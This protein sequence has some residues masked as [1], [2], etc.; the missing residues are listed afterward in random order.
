MT[1]TTFDSDEW[2]ARLGASLEALAPA[3]TYTVSFESYSSHLT[4]DEFRSIQAKAGRDPAKIRDAVAS[5]Y[6]TLRSEV[7]EQRAILHEHP[8]LKEVLEDSGGGEEMY[9]VSPPGRMSGTN[10]TMFVWVA[11]LCA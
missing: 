5:T 3:A 11:R 9:L 10:T 4:Y 6:A 7:P 1:E 8:V 2:V